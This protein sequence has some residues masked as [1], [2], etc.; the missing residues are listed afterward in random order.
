MDQAY[1]VPSTGSANKGEG[2]RSVD[3]HLQRITVY[4]DWQLSKKQ[5]IPTVATWTSP[6]KQPCK[7]PHRLTPTQTTLFLVVRAALAPHGL[8]D[9]TLHSR[10][11]GIAGELPYCTLRALRYEAMCVYVFAF[12]CKCVCVCVCVRH[13]RDS[14]CCGAA[15]LRAPHAVMRVCVIAETVCVLLLRQCLCW[16]AASLHAPNAAM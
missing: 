10:Q 12:E 1:Q 4:I 15:S 5:A 11:R 8:N 13:G 16:G 9:C 3:L 14:V 2:L 6:F 7:P